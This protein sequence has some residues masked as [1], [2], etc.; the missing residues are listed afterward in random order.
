MG[1]EITEKFLSKIHM[2]YLS[3]SVEKSLNV[4]KLLFFFNGQTKFLKLKKKK[5]EQKKKKEHFGFFKIKKSKQIQQSLQSLRFQVPFLT[6][7]NM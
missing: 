3:N 1:L 4:N 7:Q 6:V 2:F 5:N